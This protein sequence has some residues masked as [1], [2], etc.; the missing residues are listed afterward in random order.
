MKYF[1]AELAELKRNADHLVYNSV[2]STTRKSYEAVIRKMYS[3]CRNHN[4]KAKYC[5]HRDTVELFI[6]SLYNNKLCHGSLVSAVSAIKHYCKMRGYDFDFDTPRLSLMLK[7]VKRLQVVS[8]RPTNGL[9]VRELDSI[10]RASD[11]LDKALSCCTKAMFSLAFFGFLRPC[12]MATASGTPQHQLRRKAVKFTNKSV[13]L[14]FSSY[15]HSAG[16]PVV[17][18]IERQEGCYVCPWANLWR[19]VQ[20]VPLTDDDLLFP[21][22]VAFVQKVLTKC[23]GVANIAARLTLHSFRRGGAT[24]ASL[25]GWSVARVQAHGRWKSDGYKCYIKSA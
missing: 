25:R 22:T 21:Y 16:R 9:S 17:V 19:Y 1:A 6:V 11:C 12:E 14:T 2:A 20:S 4:I 13:L 5:F 8:H 18:R 23:A 7:G 24:D 3:F 10:L 15:K